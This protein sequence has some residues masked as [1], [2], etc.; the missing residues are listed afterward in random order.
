MPSTRAGNWAGPLMGRFQR[1]KHGVGQRRNPNGEEERHSARRGHANRD[2]RPRDRTAA[3]NPKNKRFDGSST[4]MMSF[5]T[6]NMIAIY[7]DEALAVFRPSFG[8]VAWP[9]GGPGSARPTPASR[10]ARGRG[11][12]TPSG[13]PA[14]RW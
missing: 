10:S 4:T 1:R 11:G 12:A 2:L 13:S 5:V 3:K 14:C 9:F 7:L 8:A 6:M